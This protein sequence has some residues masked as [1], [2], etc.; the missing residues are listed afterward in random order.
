[1]GRRKNKE[2]KRL[3]TGVRCPGFSRVSE[4]GCY[5][6]KAAQALREGCEWAESRNEDELSYRRE[7]RHTTTTGSCF[8]SERGD[9]WRTIPLWL[10]GDASAYL[11]EAAVDRS[12]D[13]A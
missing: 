4:H 10:T 7:Q 3:S 9:L 12:G 8:P 1:M 6:R 2:T 11:R 13:M 5:H